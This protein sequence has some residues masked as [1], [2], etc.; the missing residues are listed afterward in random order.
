[1][2]QL[3]QV[4]LTFSQISKCSVNSFEGTWFPHTPHFKLSCL[5]FFL[6]A[7]AFKKLIKIMLDIKSI[8][9]LKRINLKIYYFN[10]LYFFFLFP[11]LLKKIHI[12]LYIFTGTQIFFYNISSLKEKKCKKKKEGAFYQ[13]LPPKSFWST[14]YSSIF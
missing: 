12:Y 2:S 14:L 3:G 10:L 7:T 1:M 11:P 9:K 5:V 13:K 8:K 4:T 6:F